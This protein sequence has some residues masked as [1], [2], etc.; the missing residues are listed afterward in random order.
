MNG[1]L[2]ELYAK[3]REDIVRLESQNKH[4][5]E[6]AD[7]FRNVVEALHKSVDTLRL[8]VS[9]KFALLDCKVHK[10]K[11]INIENRMTVILSAFLAVVVG[12][13][14]LGLWIKGIN[15]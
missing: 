7:D 2:N 1:E 10:Q 6:R 11:L 3:L 12:G 13:I 5:S 4:H 14:V 15:G 8:L 9:D